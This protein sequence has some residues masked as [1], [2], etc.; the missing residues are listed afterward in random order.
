MSPDALTADRIYHDLKRQIML[1]HFKPESSIGLAIVAE[2]FGTSISPVR[3]ALQ[4]L[5]GERLVEIQGGGGFAIP[6]MNKKSVHQLYSWHADLVRLAV[7][8]MARQDQIEPFPGI[9]GID[10]TS[11]RHNIAEVTA[12][13]FDMIAASTTNPEHQVAIALAAARLHPLRLRESILPKLDAELESLWNVTRSANKNA[14]RLAM[15]HYHR[16]RLLK[17]KALTGAIL[18]IS[19][20]SKGLDL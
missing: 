5:V 9:D 16:R 15:W 4:R 13:L 14:I 2:E 17:A 18:D 3:D 11:R 20:N 7:K 10:P 19:G 12:R 8:G 1:G 6:A